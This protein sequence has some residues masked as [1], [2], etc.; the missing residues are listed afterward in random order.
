MKKVYGLGFLVWSICVLSQV[1]IN[2]ETPNSTLDVN[3]D[4][5]LRNALSVGGTDA[6]KGDPGVTNQ[7]LVS[8]G[9]SNAPKWMTSRVPF[10]E[11]GQYKLVSTDVVEDEIGITSLS[12]GVSGDG[13][14]VNQLGEL[15]ANNSSRSRWVKITGLS[16]PINIKS[17]KNKLVYQFQTGVEIV[18]TSASGNVRFICG[19]FKNNRLVA[20]RPDNAIVYDANSPTQY[21]YTLN[22]TE[23]DAAIG[24][25]MI[26]VACRKVETSASANYFAIGNKVYGYGNNAATPNTTSSAFAL[27][28]F[29]K[30][31]IAEDSTFKVK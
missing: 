20:M 23:E 21:I 29:F 17:T 3:G 16:L 8:Q 31:D 2:T 25:Y 28:S 5:I 12:N 19:I 10:L 26:D 6:L 13:V 30:V 9:E 1:G 27:K 11:K 24:D 15:F 7:V 18:S 22:Y 4:V 14:Y